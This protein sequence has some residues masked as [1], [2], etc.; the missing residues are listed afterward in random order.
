MNLYLPGPL[1][2]FVLAVNVHGVHHRHPG[3][4]WHDLRRAFDAEVGR[5]DAGWWT[6]MAR[7]LRGPIPS[8]AT[9]L[10]G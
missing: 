5:F 1:E 6:A 10:R 3:L 7:Q 4:A 8:S 9:R 2:L